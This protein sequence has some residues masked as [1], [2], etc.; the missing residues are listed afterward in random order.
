[1]LSDDGPP[2]SME[3]INGQQQQQQ[4]Q[5]QTHPDVPMTGDT[6]QADAEMND[7]GANR[8]LSKSVVQDF[9][10]QQRQI[11]LVTFAVLTAAGSYILMLFIAMPLS[12]HL[13]VNMNEKGC[14][15]EV[16]DD[17]FAATDDSQRTL[18]LTLSLLR[19]M[20]FLMG[21]TVG[22][23]SD[24][25][26]R[27]PLLIAALTGYSVTAILFLV[28]WTTETVGLFIFGG[29]VLGASSPV[30]PHGIAYVSDVSRPDRLATNMGILQGFGYFLGLLSG[31]LISLAI[32]E[33]TTGVEQPEGTPALDPYDKLFNISY[34]VGLCF[35][36]VVAITMFFFLP[37]SLHKDERTLKIDWKRANP[38]GF[39][40]L[41]RRSAYLTCL[42]VSAAWAWMGVG[43]L[44]AVTGGWWLRRYTQSEVNLFIIFTVMIWTGSALGAALLTPVIVKLFGLKRAIHFSMVWTILV[45][46]GL[47]FAPTANLSY[48]AVGLSFFAAPVVP[49]E[50][51][52][53]MGQVPATEKG[54]LAG[55]VRSSEAFSKL[56]GIL[57]FGSTFANYIAPFTPDVSCVPLDYSSSNPYNDCDCGVATCP[58]YDPTNSSGRV[59]NLANPFY[60]EAAEC[61]L[62]ALSP[63]FA[64]KT[65]KYIPY[66][67]PEPRPIV[68]QS[69]VDDG[70]ITRDDTCEGGGGLGDYSTLEVSREWCIGPTTLT[71]SLGS[72]LAAQFN[73]D[74]GC[75][76]FDFSLYLQD[77][78]KYENM[79]VC[80]A[81]INSADCNQTLFSETTSDP[82]SLN[83]DAEEFA[84]Y[85][86]VAYNITNDVDDPCAYFGNA[87]LNLCW[88]GVISPFPGMY[89]LIYLSGIGLMSYIFYIIAEV[90]FSDQDQ[91]YWF[92]DKSKT[93]NADQDNSKEVPSDDP[94]SV[95]PTAQT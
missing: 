10:K 61:T 55:A 85:S 43:A 88:E 70:Y 59:F 46:F 62:G 73:A 8:N 15:P 19:M 17:C 13:I 21:S 31:A 63:K 36:G 75:P 34:S 77:A 69:F 26:G 86:G 72:A 29:M 67:V 40:A 9:R 7:P 6:T 52:L 94:A 44:E 93:G 82:S 20:T 74:Y 23:V 45:G 57:L 37:E 87:E 90:C 48:I 53:I 4:Q 84:I 1:M 83:Y 89:P 22:V 27:R 76:G 47:A 33:S 25:L 35:S 50:L 42:W 71:A 12:I 41:I 65:S 80:E 49:I 58:T 79:A 68:P 51:S 60:Y 54:A 64:A 30:T 32:S 66:N 24:R 5:Q 28:G 14:D 78:P 18:T 92:H 11:A 39:L 81:D 16:Q 2:S 95:R 38:F 3:Q 56:I 91:K